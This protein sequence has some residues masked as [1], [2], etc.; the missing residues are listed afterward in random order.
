MSSKENFQAF[1]KNLIE[2]NETFYGVEM[3]EKYGDEALSASNAKMMDMTEEQYEH[4]L[5]LEARVKEL[6]ASSMEKSDPSCA[7]A[8]QACHL[9]REWLN[10][11]WKEGTYSLE[12]HRGLGEM[13]VADERFKAYYDA[14][15]VGMAEF[16]R[17][18][19]R[20]Y[21]TK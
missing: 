6:L 16:F 18:A 20:V 1:K 2:E 15:K 4:A 8:Q 13:Y 19:L 17:D 7:E 9:H 12:A 14:S 5:D 10:L 21:T 11:F 3:R